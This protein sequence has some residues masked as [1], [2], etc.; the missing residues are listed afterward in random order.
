VTRFEQTKN[1]RDRYEEIY[2]DSRHALGDPSRV[3]VEFFANYKKSTARILDI[4]CGQ[5][6]D[7]L[8]IA[9]LGHVVT[10]VDLSPTGI[11]D[12]LAEARAGGLSL[13]GIVT[14]IRT[15]TPKDCYDV[16]LLDRTLHMLTEVERVRLLEILLGYVAPGGFVLIADENSNMPAL[17]AV[18]AR[19]G[20]TWTPIREQRGYYFVR[21]SGR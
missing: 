8:F 7:A 6:R 9:R 12:M 19:S 5:G 3:F 16:L 21:R 18:I 2:S 15:F 11:A 4:G 14:D 13:S 17:K 1:L 20:V 10:G